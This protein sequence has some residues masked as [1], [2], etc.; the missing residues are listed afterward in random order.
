MLLVMNTSLDRLLSIRMEGPL[1][2]YY[3]WNSGCFQFLWYI[4]VDDQVMDLVFPSL[5]SFLFGKSLDGLG[6]DI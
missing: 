2:K 4:L 3:Q 5:F 1:A 6:K